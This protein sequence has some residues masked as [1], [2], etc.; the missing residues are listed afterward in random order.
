M[1][2]ELTINEWSVICTIKQQPHYRFVGM[3]GEMAERMVD[4]GLLHRTSKKGE[5]VVSMKGH[6]GFYEVKR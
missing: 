1:S 4:K 2:K 5:Y 3:E 6:Q